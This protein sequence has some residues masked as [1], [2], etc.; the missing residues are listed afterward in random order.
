MER[1]CFTFSIK[2]GTEQ[3]YQRRHDEI[4]PEMV[5]ALRAA[6]I[7]NYT[8]F[9]RGLGIIAYAECEPDART[10]FAAIAATDV[11][12]RWSEW[13]ADVIEQ[14]FDEHGEAMTAEEVWHL[15]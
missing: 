3:E 9:R 11:D 12:A 10:A 2:P 4:W 14:R 6:G 7:R 1:F 13:F 15:D 8:L 5:D